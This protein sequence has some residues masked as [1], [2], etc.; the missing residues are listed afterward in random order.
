MLLMGVLVLVV[1]FAGAVDADGKRGYWCWT[2]QDGD[3]GACAP[4]EEQCKASLEGFNQTAAAFREP[5]VSG[6]C[7]WQKAA[8]QLITK[9]APKPPR[10]FPTK[11][12]CT[13]GLAKGDRCKEVR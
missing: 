2:H 13:S 7:T 5:P 6:T 11:K 10:Y 1:L 8:W 4:L 3:T 12:M 9:P